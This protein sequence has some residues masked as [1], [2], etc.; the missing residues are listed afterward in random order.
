M[1]QNNRYEESVTDNKGNITKKE[2]SFIDEWLNDKDAKTYEKVDFKPCQETPEDIY[3]LFTGLEVENKQLHDT[4]IT[5]T[6]VY[7]HLFNL[8]GREENSMNY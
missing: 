3:N 5:K 7:E 4:D 8:C 2:K 1:Y 6:K